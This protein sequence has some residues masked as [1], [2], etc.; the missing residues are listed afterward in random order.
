MR[1]QGY[2]ILERNLRTRHG[3]ID[4]LVQ[5]R[6]LLVAVEVKT[7]GA[8]PA[9]EWCLQQAQLARLRRSLLALWHTYRPR[10]RG[11]RVDV[12]TVNGRNADTP[13]EVTHFPGQP[14]PPDS[15]DLDQ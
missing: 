9:P 7:R 14:F 6:R 13:W 2:R 3:E 1:A 15:P 4:L 11:L 10:P 5:N 8:H 12:V